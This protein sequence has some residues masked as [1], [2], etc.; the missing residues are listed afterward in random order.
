MAHNTST[1]TAVPTQGP[2][3]FA[4]LEKF[5]AEEDAARFKDILTS[6]VVSNG[7][8]G[9][10]ASLV[11]DPGDTVAYPGGFFVNE[12]GTITYNDDTANHWVII[13]K[14]TTTVLGGDWI[15]V[16]G[17]HYFFDPVAS[18]QPATPVDAI[19]I[20]DV[21]TASGSITTVT[22]LRPLDAFTLPADSGKV[23]N[24]AADTTRNFLASKIVAGTNITLTTL[25]PGGNETLEI[26]SQSRT[27]I[28][29][30]DTTAG[31]L[32]DKITVGDGLVTSINNGFGN[33]DL[34]LDV[35]LSTTS[36]L[37]FSSA[38]L[39]INTV[40]NGGLAL[41][42]NGIVVD[43]A[44][45][46]AITVIDEVNDEVLVEDFSQTGEKKR[47]IT[48]ANFMLNA[49]Q[50]QA[51]TGTLNTGKMT[52]LRVTESIDLGVG[53]E[54]HFGGSGTY[55]VP[56]RITEVRVI[57]YAGGGGG[58]ASQ[59]S[60]HGGA[61]G[62]AGG[63]IEAL[64]TVTPGGTETVTIGAAGAAGVATSG[65]GG[66]GGSTTFGSLVTANGGVG[67]SGNGATGGAGG[68]AS[69]TGTQVLK[70]SGRPGT[71]GL[72]SGGFDGGDGG[73]NSHSE[74]AG[75]LGTTST[76]GA[77]GIQTSDGGAGGGG[78]GG[79]R[80]G[81]AGVIGYMIVIPIIAE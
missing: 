66:T 43:I 17:T 6:F 36:G 18:S 68:T 8:H 72:T 34:Q 41:N 76:V 39:Q 12:T 78:S 35:K 4:E 3:F 64:V 52:S 50:A 60:V 28:S 23:F 62:G 58:E 19:M 38:E 14:D 75:P 53:R 63:W 2:A 5:L 37:E 49:T 44:G 29:T 24:T 10:G 46:S 45:T 61:G 15:R 20:M 57:A 40:A 9:T 54:V 56:D 59:A 13:Y 21:V 79:S 32:D 73:G 27:T 51:A 67:G 33:E 74:D 81:G 80:N 30:N 31:F 16:S 65:D 48:V 70:S 7:L 42:A 26:T 55:N 25:T 11:G 77:A 22:D 47:A 69:T 71:V 1:K